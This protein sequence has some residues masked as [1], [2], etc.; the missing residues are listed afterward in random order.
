VLWRSQSGDPLRW[1]GHALERDLTNG[2]THLLLAQILAARGARNQALLELRL[3][4]EA[5]P[6]LAGPIAV[7]AKQWAKHPDDVMRAVPAGTTGA[8]I[9]IALA[10]NVS[11]A[12]IELRLR[13]LEH[14]IERDPTAIIARKAHAQD[15]LRAIVEGVRPCAGPERDRCV[16]RVREDAEI[17]TRTDS[18]DSSG[19]EIRARLLVA[20]GAASEAERAL[21]ERCRAYGKRLTCQRTRLEIAL[22]LDNAE[23]VDAALKELFAAACPPSK[24]CAVEATWAGDFIARAGPKHVRLAVTAY[25][26]AVQNEPTADRWLR[27][28]GSASQAGLHGEAVAALEKVVRIRGADPAL[29]QRIELERARV[30]GAVDR[31]P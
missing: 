6:G 1:I 8:Q 19:E 3:A 7:H 16:R 4:A 27:L 28:A 22:A 29:K 10:S 15:I 31:P 9:L 20:S 5:E 12:E 21:S 11:R 30:F 2:R 14:A 26:R 18:S 25:R 24:V 17:L 13:L 23:R